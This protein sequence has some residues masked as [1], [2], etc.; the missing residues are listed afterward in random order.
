MTEL[1]FSKILG[2]SANTYYKL[3]SNKTKAII[4]KT[5]PISQELIEQIRSDLKMRGYSNKK[6]NYVEFLKLF[7]QYKADISE[8]DFIIILNISESAYRGIKYNN[9]TTEILKEKDNPNVDDEEIR[10]DC[11]QKGY[12]NKLITYDEF[13][14]LYKLYENHL[15]E[16]EFADIL[17]M[18][19]YG[20]KNLKR[21]TKARILGFQKV[22]EENKQKIAEKLVEQG[23][24]NKLITYQEFLELYNP[25]K[26]EMSD[27]QFAEIL[28]ISYNGLNNL[29]KTYHNR[30]IILKIEKISEETTFQIKQLFK[31]KGYTNKKI[32]YQEFLELY[33]PYQ[34]EMTEKQFAGILNVSYNSLQAIKEGRNQTTIILPTS[35]VSAER[36]EEI[37]I[38]M[39]KNHTG[40]KIG[41]NEFL[42]F[43]EPYEEEMTKLDFAKILGISK[44]CYG[45]LMYYGER[46]KILEDTY[47]DISKKVVSELKESQ[48]DGRIITKDEFQELYELYKDIIPQNRFEEILGFHVKK[49]GYKYKINLRKQG[50]DRVNYLLSFE[51]RAYTRDE[52][53]KMCSENEITLYD[54][55]EYNH[56]HYLTKRKNEIIENLLKKDRIYIGKFIVPKEFQEE[57][58]QELL[59]FSIMISKKHAKRFRQYENYEDIASDSLIYVL[60]NKGELVLN[61][62]NDEEA[63]SRIRAY[64]YIVIKQR[65]IQNGIANETISLDDTISKNDDR[66]RYEVIKSKD[67]YTQEEM[68][69]THDSIIQEMENLYNIGMDNDE[70][71]NLMMKKHKLGKKELLDMLQEELLKRRAIKQ[72]T[73]GKVYL[74]EEL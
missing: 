15:T 50:I 51:A 73:N 41:L 4:L 33:K 45:S 72:T 44:Y 27:R 24:T 36:K 9:R 22:T 28:G 61:A 11:R 6:I 7:Q 40:E 53:D 20:Y 63:L 62:E 17:G 26:D 70:T 66:K 10:N 12:S 13:L 39:K 34:L 2:I 58:A 57:Y 35:E 46:V 52:L 60:S 56:N 47:E 18:S 42:Q 68:F 30:V 23:Y 25:Y 38:E 5:E 54:L 43:Y 19:F 37:Y 14:V 64:L 71:M 3:K 8:I 16:Q 1:E 21:G 49:D 69:N 74:G 67:I 55:L 48:Y 59:N 29:R 65:Y 32:S 31:D